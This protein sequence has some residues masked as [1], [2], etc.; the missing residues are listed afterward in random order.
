LGKLPN[1]ILED[2][3]ISVSVPVFRSIS[4]CFS[5]SLTNPWIEKEK[6]F[7]GIFV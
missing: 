3:D 7:D 1:L 2:R 5:G 4:V 6:S